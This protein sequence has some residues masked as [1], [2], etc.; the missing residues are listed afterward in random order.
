M[1]IQVKLSVI[2]ILLVLTFGLCSYSYYQYQ[3]GP[4]SNDDK[5]IKVAVPV[6]AS[7]TKIADLL[8][9][10]KLIKNKFFFKVYL[11]LKG[12]GNLKHGVYDLSPNLGTKRIVA[13]LV[14]GTSLTGTEIDLLFKEGINIRGIARVIAANTN[15]E[16]TAVFTLL[17]DETYIEQLINEYWFLTET[18]K[19]SA[20]YYPLEGYLAPDTYRFASPD[21]SVAD[22][23]KAMLKQTDKI[24]TEYRTEL[25][26]G[27]FSL[28]EFMTFASIVQSEG[29][30]SKDMPLIAGVFY[31]RLNRNIPFESCVTNCYAT[32]TDNCLPT[33]VNK[34]FNSPYNTYLGSLVGKLPVGPVS[35]PGQVAI[36]SSFY[37]EVHDYLFF[38]ADIYNETYF[39]KTNKE[40]EQQI[41]ALKAAGIWP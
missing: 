21:V 15:N 40:H 33:K 24:L 9:E 22:I 31:N 27:T 38:C 14:K 3:L 41:K 34:K 39:T 23:F 11:K 30:G 25:E 8:I 18:I 32:K 20:L 10:N 5:I 29:R 2:I 35:N 6:A 17:Q 13:L 7:G 1:K 36:R 4:V 26:E 37:P 19:D 28:H 16:E 12:I